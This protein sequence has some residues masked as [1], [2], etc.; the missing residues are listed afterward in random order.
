MN[1]TKKPMQP[2]IVESPYAG[3]R[4]DVPLDHPEARNLAYLRAAMHDCVVR[5]RQSPYASHAILT[6]PGVL[7]DEVPEERAL[8]I[9]AGFDLGEILAIAGAPRVFYV[10]LGWS[11][12][13]K[14]GLA[15]AKR[16]GQRI[17]E[18]TLP[19]WAKE[20]A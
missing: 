20:A 4:W 14:A 13:M 2:V 11:G 16:L 7:R 1:E 8:G 17:E 5:H 9:Q 15:E 10:D 3:A 19:G 18:R 6:Q 12:G